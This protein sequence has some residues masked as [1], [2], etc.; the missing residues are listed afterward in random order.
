MRPWWVAAMLSSGCLP[1]QPGDAEFSAAALACQGSPHHARCLAEA[2]CASKGKLLCGGAC[3]TSDEHNCGGCG[4]VCPGGECVQDRCVRC[5]LDLG[6]DPL[7]PAGETTTQLTCGHLPLGRRVTVSMHGTVAAGAIGGSCRSPKAGACAHWLLVIDV[8]EHVQ[9]RGNACAAFYNA[10][11]PAD[12]T[13][14]H[15]PVPA[16]GTVRAWVKLKEVTI[17]GPDSET[18]HGNANASGTVLEIRVEP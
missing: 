9:V 18:C 4:I 16:D 13:A 6:S 2:D 5:W 10:P 12:V 7:I 8:G 17:S 3:A 11:M 1:G 14:Q 15:V